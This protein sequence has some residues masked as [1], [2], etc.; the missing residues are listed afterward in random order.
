MTPLLKGAL[1][2]YGAFRMSNKLWLRLTVDSNML[3]RIGLTVLLGIAW[4]FVCGVLFQ[5][6]GFEASLLQIQLL[7]NLGVQSVDLLKELIIITDAIVWAVV[8]G[9]MFG[10]PLAVLVSKNVMRYWGLFFITASLLVTEGGV[11]N[12]NGP[13]AFISEI[14]QSSYLAYQAGI[15]AVWFFTAR[16]LS[17]REESLRQEVPSL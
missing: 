5:Q 3:K 13:A 6:I 17:R 2:H 10:L 1:A 4:P 14:V 15:L 16:A 9:L 8:F 11:L 12:G 7:Q